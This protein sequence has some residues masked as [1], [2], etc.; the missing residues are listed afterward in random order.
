MFCSTGL[1]ELGK[2]ATAYYQVLSLGTQVYS[3]MISGLGLGG[4]GFRVC[5]RE[6]IHGAMRREGSLVDDIRLEEPQLAVD[7][8]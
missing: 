8:A 5:G 4:L 2:I 7:T 6:R 1:E 3:F